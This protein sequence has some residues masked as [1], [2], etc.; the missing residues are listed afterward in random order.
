MTSDTWGIMMVTL[1]ANNTDTNGTEM[2][3]N[4]TI[5]GD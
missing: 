5:S 1:D 4:G 2:V 3:L